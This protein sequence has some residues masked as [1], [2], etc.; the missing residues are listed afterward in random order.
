MFNMLRD[1]EALK[2]HIPSLQR[3]PEFDV[4]EKAFCL[5]NNENV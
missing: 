2:I 1:V 3:C 4:D 5:K